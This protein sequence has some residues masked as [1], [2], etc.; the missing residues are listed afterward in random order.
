MASTFIKLPVDG[1]SGPAAGVDS[2]N[3]RTGV[4]VSQAGD[5]AA[6]IIANTPAGNI[7][8]TN[9]QAAINELD[10]EKQATITGGASSIV[11]ANLTA[12]R[13]LQS[14][15]SGKVA[16]SA[17]TAAE[18]AHVSGVTSAIQTQ[19]DNKQ[20]LDADLS[21]LAALATTGIVARTGAGTVATRTITGSAAV[22]VTNGDGVVANPT[23]DLPNSGVVPGSY[24]NPNFTVDAKGKVIAASNGS[25]P[26]YTPDLSI[27][28]S[29]D[30][31]GNSVTAGSY[32]WTVNNAGAGASSTV[33]STLAYTNT[34]ERALGVMQQNTGSTSTGRSMVSTG[35]SSLRTGFATLDMKM[36]CA[37][38]TYGT[39]T[40]QYQFT[41]GGVSNTAATVG[42]AEGVFF[43][44]TGDGTN[45]VWSCV[46]STGGVE[47]E[48]ITSVVA[49]VGQFQLFQII[50]N[51]TATQVQFLIN[52]VLV[53]THTTNIPQNTA[54]FGFGSKILKTL[55]TTSI[56][57]LVDYLSLECSWDAA[58]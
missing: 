29:D 52:G 4:V 15:G 49:T 10:A 44:F 23:I 35:I 22:T 34:T 26:S 48:T 3:G 24:T 27:I 36:R 40:E 55:G 39:L 43:R 9:V 16:V 47:T 28:V 41:F 57:T 1:G 25:A 8:A 50:I 32:A 7:S 5:Y 13:A 18:L 17:V 20:P 30:F 46:T 12:S 58:R 33:V 38:D 6:G 56:I 54:T 2:F 37:I 31:I 51:N 53:A 45:T 42:H 14:D 21:A 11:T 19:L